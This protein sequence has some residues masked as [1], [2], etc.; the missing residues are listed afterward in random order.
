LLT[1]PNADSKIDVL[2][3]PEVIA[4]KIRTAFAAP[5]VV[6]D[7]GILAFTEFVLLPAAGL[8]GKREFH[9]S[10]EKDG[11]EPLVYTTIEAMHE[12][13]KK[14]VVSALRWGLENG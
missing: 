1:N 14:E 8:K 6:E 2:D 3:P 9:V 7:N 12:D 13:Y 4:K 11:L 10:R 5:G